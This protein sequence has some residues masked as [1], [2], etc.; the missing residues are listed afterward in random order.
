MKRVWVVRH[1]KSA[2]GSPGQTDHDRP[3]NARGNKNGRAMQAWYARQERRAQWVWSSSA[4]R[5][6]STAEF[7][8]AGMDG[9]LVVEPSLYLSTPETLLGVLRGTPEHIGEQT[10]DA[11]ALVAHNPGITAFVNLLVGRRVVDNM[12]TF[13]SAQ[14]DFDCAWEDIDFGAGTLVDITVPRSL[15]ET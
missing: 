14:I 4:V 2:E 11:T 13:A 3:L 5:A 10:V 9:E 12:V 7:V 8:A 6:H 15:P 1:G